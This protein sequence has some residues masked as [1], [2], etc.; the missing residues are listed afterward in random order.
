MPGKIHSQAQARFIGAIAGGEVH[1][2]GLSAETAK[3]MLRGE[4][5]A[6]LPEHAPK[7]KPH[8]KKP[9]SRSQVSKRS[10]TAH[11]SRPAKSTSSR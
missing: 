3:E 5:V 10:Q 1:R 6:G 2:K 9:A 4:N 7:P 8:R 11:S